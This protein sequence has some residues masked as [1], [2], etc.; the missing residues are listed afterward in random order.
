MKDPRQ[1][2]VR[3]LVTEKGMY[4][5][6]KT[7]AY[8]FEVHPDANKAEIKTAIEKLFDVKVIEVR[9]MNRQGKLRRRRH[10]RYGRT[11]S[12]KKAVVTLSR[13]N[14]IEII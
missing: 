4:F 13:D 8:P 11:R 2:I 14:T 12:W 10:L 6:E 3:P 9:T 5:A 1:I 7:K